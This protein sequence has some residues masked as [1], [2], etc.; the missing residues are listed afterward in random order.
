[1]RVPEDYIM[2]TTSKKDS[3]FGCSFFLI[4]FIIGVIVLACAT[5]YSAPD[6][7]LG[8][9][10]ADLWADI[11]MTVIVFF[12]ISGVITLLLILIGAFSKK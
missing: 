6:S 9:W 4:L 1:M 12:S 7:I 3:G 5:G 11:K 8:E 10:F 2:G